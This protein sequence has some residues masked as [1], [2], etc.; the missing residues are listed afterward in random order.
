MLGKYVR[1]EKVLS[2]EAAIRKM[3]AKPAEVFGLK[4]RGLLREGYYA[5]LV[6]FNPETIKDK[7]DYVNP[8]QYPAGIEYV[9][10][11]GVIAVSKDRQED[12]LPGRVLRK[13]C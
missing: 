5:D 1:E 6:V 4:Q 13:K 7:G 2:L 12:A 10:V 3:T 11:N 8:S 9:L